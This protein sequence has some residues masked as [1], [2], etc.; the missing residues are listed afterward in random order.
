MQYLLRIKFL[1]MNVKAHERKVTASNVKM[2]EVELY[3]LKE[4]K[5]VN[6]GLEKKMIAG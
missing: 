2:N 3:W 6:I 1:I 5:L 4:I